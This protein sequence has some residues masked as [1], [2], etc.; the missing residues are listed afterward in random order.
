[1]T[2]QHYTEILKPSE[3]YTYGSPYDGFAEMTERDRKR[4]NH[5]GT[6]GLT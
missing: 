5:T 1:M 4:I 2:E 3:E 6:Q